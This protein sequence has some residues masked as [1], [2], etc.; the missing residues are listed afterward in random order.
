MPF[1]DGGQGEFGTY[2]I[3]LLEHPERHRADAEHMFI[4]DPPGNYDRILDF[5]TAVTGTLFLR[6]VTDFLDD[7]PPA[8]ALTDAATPVETAAANSRD[9]SDTSLG[10]GSLRRSSP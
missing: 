2:Y 10:I 4:G 6:A 9:T 5:S 7:P 8:H 1:G 3:A